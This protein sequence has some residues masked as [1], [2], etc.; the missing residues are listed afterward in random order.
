M[1]K[2]IKP[3]LWSNVFNHFK[4]SK[5]H[6]LLP[7]NTIDAKGN[8]ISRSTSLESTRLLKQ[9]T[10]ITRTSS[11]QQ[12][13]VTSEQQKGTSGVYI[14]TKDAYTLTDGPTIFIAKDL[15]KIAKFCIQQS[16]IPKVV[17]DGIIEKINYNNNIN[18][19][20][21]QIEKDL[22]LEEEKL[23]T[24]LSGSVDDSSKEAKKL[25]GQK[26]GKNR[27][28]L[29][30]KIV[31]KTEDRKIAKMR[32]D[33]MTLK[34]MIKHASIDDMFIPNKKAHIEKWAKGLNSNSS[35]TSN[36]EESINVS[37]MMLKD[38]EDT[39]KILLLLGIGVFTNHESIA[40]TEIMKRLADQQKLYLII[41]D[42]DYIYGTNYQFC[43]GYLSKDLE[44][45]QE[46]II[47]ALGRIGRNNIQQEYT[48]RFR[49]TSQIN[50]LFAKL[51]SEE[52]QEVIN[53]NQL[54]NCRNVKWNGTDYEEIEVEE[55]N[56]DYEV[57]DLEIDE[58]M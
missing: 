30:G 58:V 11:V 42:S 18:E 25:L 2:N 43:H 47:Q 54:F 51:T 34:T 26:D 27:S 57:D 16:N 9:G 20:I 12:T 1:L 56:D 32:E 49:D 40:Y 31:D 38:V 41:A 44:L 5:K 7:N 13:T 46:K 52:K 21:D 8:V 6:R 4:I 22:E 55:D 3:E 48:A 45:T 53:M 33:I 28:K 17:M 29:A 36:I 23:A 50:M 15:P 37:I 14:T 35:F 39:W 24:K 19:R 10:T